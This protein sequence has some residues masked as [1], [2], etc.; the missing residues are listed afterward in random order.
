MKIAVL[1]SGILP[2][3][4]VLGG[5]VENLIDFYLEYNDKHRLH[6]ITVYS[7]ADNAVKK[8]PALK[9]NV[10]HYKYIDINSLTARIRMRITHAFQH[11][12]Y[13]YYAIEYYFRQALKDIRRQNYDMIIMEN[14]PGYAIKLR[15]HTTA[16]LVLHLHNDLL[17]STTHKYSEIY[18]ATDAV[19]CVSDYIARQVKTITPNDAKTTVVYNGIDTTAFCPNKSTG[20]DRKQFGLSDKDFVLLFSG[21]LY[22]QKG[23]S[24]LIDAMI[25]L[26]QHEDIKLLTIGSSFFGNVSGDDDFVTRLKAKAGQIKD[27]I[28]FTGFIPYAHVPEYLH[29]CDV[30]VIPSVWNEPLGLTC[31]EG[32]AAG[33]PVITTTKGGIPEIATTECAIMLDTGTGFSDRLS[34]AILALYYDADRR[35]NMAEASLRRSKLFTKE[36]Y[37]ENFF[38]AIENL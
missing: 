25:T 4:A 21:R 20:L 10:N 32:M 27:R 17:N 8:H 11:D 26:R 35:R 23:I 24:E 2:M 13:Y 16:K 12:E 7:V 22:E 18:D 6:D 37:A 19:V 14:R 30:A 3:P 33:L 34:D 15:Q 36:R 5:A 29:I 38:K 1:T 28:I 9:S 31:L